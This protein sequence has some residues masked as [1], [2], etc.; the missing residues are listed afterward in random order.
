LT[1]LGFKGRKKIVSK[2][3]SSKDLEI[4]PG[5]WIDGQMGVK[6]SLRIAYSNKKSHKSIG[7]VFFVILTSCLYI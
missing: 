3:G 6:A 7:G 4:L 2:M 1:T 5:R